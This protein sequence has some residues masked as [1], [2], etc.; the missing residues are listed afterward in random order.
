MYDNEWVQK[1]L[2]KALGLP[3]KSDVV[4]SARE[5]KQA[6]IRGSVSQAA[7]ASATKKR[8]P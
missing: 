6:E 2:R 3:A 8:K 5:G 7:R 1:E 4:D